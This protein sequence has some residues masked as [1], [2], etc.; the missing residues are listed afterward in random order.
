MNLPIDLALFFVVLLGFFVIGLPLITSRVSVPK[1]VEF[2]DIPD[3][4]LSPAQTA[5]FARLD[6]KLREVGYRPHGNRIPTN[7]Q[8][9]ALVR[10]YLSDADPAIIMMNLLTSEV[11][12]SGEHPMNYL[13]VMTRHDDGTI[14]STRNAE[15]SDVL[16]VLPGHVI[17]ERRGLRDPSSLKCAHDRKAEEFKIRG[18]I[19][20][21]ADEFEQSFHEYHE[22]WCSHQV[23]RGL[24]RT[25]AGDEDRLRPTVKAG[26]RGITNFLNPFADNFTPLRLL[27]VATF[28]LAGPGAAILWLGGPG[29]PV[30]SR[31]SALTGLDP[32]WC[33]IA[34]L[35][36]V[37][38]VAGAVVGS[39]FVSK[40]FI[41][42][43][44][45]TYV[46]LRI[47]GPPGVGHDP[48]IE[49][50]YRWSGGLGCA[51]A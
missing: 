44:L 2:E 16:D 47:L 38:T 30:V 7:M 40:A 4:D 15:I 22:R 10:L 46:L 41:W 27:L 14:L 32:I 50:V 45:L 3:H 29:S 37:F 39:I 19:F 25:E 11:E 42:S 20:S 21:R 49:F 1:R 18:P 51:A 23:N 5:F 48:D 35:G 36:V 24:L 13:E 12:G 34:C 6:P 8:G 43:F 28:G 33:L 17:Q 26:V 31:L 9:R